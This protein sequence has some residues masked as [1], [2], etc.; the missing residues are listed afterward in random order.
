MSYAVLI[1]KKAEKDIVILSK[2][3]FKRVRAVLEAISENPFVG[4]KLVGDLKG[5]YSIR[6]WPYRIVY[7]IKKQKLIVF[8]L[9]VGHRKEVYK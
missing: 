7:E 3:D 2:Q 9:R 5:Y 6:V 4:K 1:S 8:V